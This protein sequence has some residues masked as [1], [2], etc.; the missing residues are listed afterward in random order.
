MGQGIEL[1]PSVGQFDT[2]GSWHESIVQPAAE[3]LKTW[4]LEDAI[5]EWR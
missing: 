3:W 5:L 4:K 1:A 2:D